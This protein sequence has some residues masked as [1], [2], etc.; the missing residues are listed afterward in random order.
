MRCIADSTAN[1]AVTGRL[2]ARLDLAGAASDESWFREDGLLSAGAEGQLDSKP[3]EAGVL[4]KQ[5]K[6]FGNYMHTARVFNAFREVAFPMTNR[7]HMGF[8]QRGKLG[9]DN[10]HGVCRANYRSESTVTPVNPDACPRGSSG[11]LVAA[12]DHDKDG[13][14]RRSKAKRCV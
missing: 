7:R 2:A 8:G 13:R 9:H 3:H 12:C 11:T 10:A 5:R 4:Q 1:A 6:I 14:E